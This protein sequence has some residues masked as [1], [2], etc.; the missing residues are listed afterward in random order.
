MTSELARRTSGHPTLAGS[1]RKNVDWPGRPDSYAPT[2]AILGRQSSNKRTRPGC[3]FTANGE[4]LTWPKCAAISLVIGTSRNKSDP[5]L[6]ISPTLSPSSTI[7][8][9]R[10]APVSWF[11]RLIS[12]IASLAA[13]IGGARHLRRGRI[14]VRG[15]AKHGDDRLHRSRSVRIPFQPLPHSE[16]K[17]IPSEGPI[18]SICIGTMQFASPS[19]NH[20]ASNM[21]RGVGR[22]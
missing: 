14:S 22:P 17:V 20:F 1:A 16:K 3:A 4:L 21:L 12:I 2:P 5:P 8:T 15:V 7:A 19:A 13:M 6:R 9:L 18:A 11:P 10:Y